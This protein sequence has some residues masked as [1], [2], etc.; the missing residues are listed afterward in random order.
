[1]TLISKPI[2]VGT[3]EFQQKY[4]YVQR[5]CVQKIYA[6][7]NSSFK[8]KT[9]HLFCRKTI[10]N[11]ICNKCFLRKRFVS[12]VAGRNNLKSSYMNFTKL[13]FLIKFRFQLYEQKDQLVSISFSTLQTIKKHVHAIIEF[14]IPHSRLSVKSCLRQWLIGL[15]NFKLIYSI[16]PF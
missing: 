2:N 7:Y 16:S 12:Y 5:I 14:N 4:V 13:F 1:M 3:Y 8:T 11:K 6:K 15:L 9:D 10:A